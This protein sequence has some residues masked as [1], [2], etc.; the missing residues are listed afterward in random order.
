[1]QKRSPFV[2]KFSCCSMWQECQKENRC[3]Q[4]GNSVISREE[5]LENCSVARR[6][7]KKEKAE[8]KS[9]QI[10]AGKTD[11]LSFLF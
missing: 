2:E 11:Q 6:Y 10:E 9:V 8:E 7:R 4:P 3:V 1:M 5:Y